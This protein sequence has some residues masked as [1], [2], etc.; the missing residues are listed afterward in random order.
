MAPPITIG[1]EIELIAVFRRTRPETTPSHGEDTLEMFPARQDIHERLSSRLPNL[2]LN[3]CSAQSFGQGHIKWT[4]KGDNTIELNENEKERLPKGC[5]WEGVEITSRV[6][7]YDDDWRGEIQSVMNALLSFNTKGSGYWLL[8]NNKTHFHVHIARGDQC[9]DFNSV[10]R[11]YYLATTFERQIDM[12]HSVHRIGNRGR[13]RPPSHYLNRRGP[14]LVNTPL[15]WLDR[16]AGWTNPIMVPGGHE[17]AY[18]TN[19]MTAVEGF[20][21]PYNTLEFRQHRGTLRADEMIAW[22]EFV[23]SLIKHAE[24]TSEAS[25]RSFCASNAEDH[26]FSTSDLLEHIGLPSATRAFYNAQLTDPNRAYDD[27]MAI[28]HSAELRSTS[29]SEANEF[30]PLMMIVS[31]ANYQDKMLRNVHARVRQR[32]DANEYGDFGLL[33]KDLLK[34]VH[35]S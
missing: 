23:V 29:L 17:A 16:I 11:L 4:V 15:G 9:I 2:R 10:K 35:R 25:V 24:R 1:I 7:R 8:N 32:I 34:G 21:P 6:M 20:P 14:G 22:T 18:N 13:A 33:T 27:Q 31:Q 26:L 12:M 30:L 5:V 28:L 3:E 19:N